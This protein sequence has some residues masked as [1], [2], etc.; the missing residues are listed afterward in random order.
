[1]VVMILI[2]VP[3]PP[4]PTNQRQVFRA[5]RAPLLNEGLTCVGPLD[6]WLAEGASRELCFAGIPAG[7]S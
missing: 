1:M 4:F 6:A 2:I 7:I 5:F 3:I